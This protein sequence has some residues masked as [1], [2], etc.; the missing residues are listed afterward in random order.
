MSP[1]T[2][3]ERFTDRLRADS[4]WTA[5]VDNRFT[6]E[7]AA[8]ALD[9]D[10]FARYLV[11]DYAFL[12]ELVSLFGRALSGA[13]TMVAKGRFASFLGTLTDEEND[14]FERSFAALDVPP[15]TYED[16]APTATTAAFRDHLRT[17]GATGGY[18]ETLAVLVPAEWVYLDWAT[19]VSE[20]PEPFYL[21]EW[22]DLHDND[23][24]AAF[25]AWMREELD[26]EGEA[27][28]GRRRE[29][30]A[31]LFERTVRLEAEF[32]GAAYDV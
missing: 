17:A 27:L 10:V 11:Q 30:V 5:A 6:Q 21:A 16:P 1:D 3:A 7:L 4:D 15:A 29:R 13:P 12:D 20:R 23:E 31:R 18:A 32:F 25:V 28:S 19:D 8:G 14:Y 26:R 22:V 24:F 2:D 9:D